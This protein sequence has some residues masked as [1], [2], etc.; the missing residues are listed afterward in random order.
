MVK[1]LIAD[2]HPLLRRGVRELLEE[3]S[4]FVVKGEAANGQEVLKHVTNDRWNLVIMDITMPG[5]NGLEVLREVKR[6]R[7][8]LPVLILSMHGGEEF[9][10]RALKAGASGYLTKDAAL[11]ELI[12]AIRKIIGGGKYLSPALAEQVAFTKS[13]A[14]KRRI[15]S[16]SEREQQV[17]EMIAS[18]NSLKQI[19]VELAVSAKTVTTYR[20]R[21]LDKL[22]L[23]NNADLTRHVLKHRLER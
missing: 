5:R 16:L 9:V 6:L 15:A 14:F 10:E 7:P 20:C 18:G 8:Q 12:R 17:L 1:I 2:D 13:S 23:K 21:V 11:N 3:Q 4:D 19:A 22:K